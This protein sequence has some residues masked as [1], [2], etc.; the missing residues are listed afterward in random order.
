MNNRI[1]GMLLALLAATGTGVNAQDIYENVDSQG[2]VEFSDE[3]AA[4]AKPVEVQPN[5]IDVTPVPR[6]EPL[7]PPPENKPAAPDEEVTTV[8]EHQRVIGAEED[9]IEHRRELGTAVEAH[10]DP[11]EHEGERHEEAAHAGAHHR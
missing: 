5:V 11:V 7:R 2:G 1:P 8:V 4:G 6:L 10:R 9:E 3:A